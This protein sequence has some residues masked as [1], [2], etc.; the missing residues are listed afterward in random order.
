MSTSYVFFSSSKAMNE[1]RGQDVVVVPFYEAELQFHWLCPCACCSK[2]GVPGSPSASGASRHW[3]SCAK[4]SSPP[5]SGY[6]VGMSPAGSLPSGEGCWGAWAGLTCSWSS[7]TGAQGRAMG[8]ALG[9][10]NGPRTFHG[11][12]RS[13]GT[14]CP[15]GTSCVTWGQCALCMVDKQHWMSSLVLLWPQVKAYWKAFLPHPNSTGLWLS[16]WGGQ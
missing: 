16:Q 2:D 8:T 11:W 14:S 15:K 10:C 9:A 7:G 4:P 1:D 12:G 6:S 5:I 3:C 13:G